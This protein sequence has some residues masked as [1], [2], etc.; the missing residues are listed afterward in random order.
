V[1]AFVAASGFLYASLEPVPLR[2]TLRRLQR[3]LI[4][5]LIASALAPVWHLSQGEPRE[6]ARIAFDLATGASFGPYYYVFVITVLVCFTPLIAGANMRGLLLVWA[7]ILYPVIALLQQSGALE[8]GGDGDLFWYGRHPLHWLQYFLLG[9]IVRFRYDALAG[10]A[11]R[12][13]KLLAPALAV[14]VALLVYAATPGEVGG[15]TFASWFNIYASIALVFVVAAGVVSIPAWLHRLSDSS[16]AIYLFHLFFLYAAQ[17]GLEAVGEVP[18][19]VSILV[20]WAAG[21]LGGVGLV[22]AVR[23]ALG[24]RARTWLGA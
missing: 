8:P 14:I 1:P 23:A 3:I 2:T 18:R 7:L 4:P 6:L 20:S 24:A 13:K 9:W 16:Y 5:Y 12:H 22:V 15:S 10:F 19:G 11:V 17:V 21:L